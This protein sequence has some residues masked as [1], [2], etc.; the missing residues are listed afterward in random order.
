MTAGTMGRCNDDMPCK[1]SFSH[2]TIVKRDCEN[3]DTPRPFGRKSR[4]ASSPFHIT[5]CSSG[6]CAM[7][8]TDFS[9]CVMMI[10]D[11]TTQCDQSIIQL[12]ARQRRPC[13]QDC[14]RFRNVVA[15]QCH[16]LLS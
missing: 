5:N 10:K 8:A 12:R 3:Y 14:V 4:A 7:A 1:S 2:V 11:A 6:Y 9:V 16:V 15:S 13:F